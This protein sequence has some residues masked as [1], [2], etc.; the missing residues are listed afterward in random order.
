MDKIP[1]FQ[2]KKLPHF[3]SPTLFL[4]H[5]SKTLPIAT[6][7]FTQASMQK[8]VRALLILQDRD[9][10]LLALAKDL[11]KLPQDEARAKAKLAGD[12]AAVTK[13]HQALLDC[14]L[15]VKKIELDAE[16]RRTTI[17]RLKNQQFETRKNE[18]FVAL[19][20][21][22]VRYEK[23]LDAF[24]TQELEAMD[25]VDGYRNAQKAAEAAREKTKA[26][27]TEDLASLKQRHAQT[28]ADQAEVL[29][30]REKLLADVPEDLIPLYNRLMKGKDGLA[31]APL[32]DGKCEG[33]HM[34]LIASTVMNV[35]TAKEIT[36]CEDCGRILYEEE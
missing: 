36:Q 3:A 5:I 35:Q 19:G 12:E 20:H 4:L 7:P 24:E 8:E 14:E 11:A 17:K 23:D 33:C 25:E 31:I 32:R 9:R 2:T 34:K 10:R 26:L 28:L 15:R 21:E 27:V 16:T 6:K 13:A 29:A 30:Q 22:I 18:E 1:A